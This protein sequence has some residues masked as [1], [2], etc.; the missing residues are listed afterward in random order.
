M[1]LDFNM[2]P[3]NSIKFIII[4]L[5]LLCLCL[6]V[7]QNESH[8]ASSQPSHIMRYQSTENIYARADE[9]SDIIGHCYF[10]FEFIVTIA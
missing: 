1:G 7:V 10:Y 5:S 4:I 9:M 6:A 3:A 8:N 2:E